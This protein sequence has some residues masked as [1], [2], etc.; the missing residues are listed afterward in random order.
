MWWGA[1]GGLKQTFN[2]KGSAVPS[3]GDPYWHSKARSAIRINLAPHAV[4]LMPF[5]GHTGHEMHP[6]TLTAFEKDA[7]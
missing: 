5:R 2:T 1:V 4:L 7:C 3:V 6:H